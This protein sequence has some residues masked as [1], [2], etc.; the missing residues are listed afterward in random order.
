MSIFNRIYYYYM[1]F[2]ELYFEK[3][4]KKTERADNINSVESAQKYPCFKLVFNHN[5]N[6][7]GCYTW[8]SLWYL[9]KSNKNNWYYIGDLKIK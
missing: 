2:M 6:D 4:E 5:W 9:E 7:Y 1:Q 3:Q 8:F